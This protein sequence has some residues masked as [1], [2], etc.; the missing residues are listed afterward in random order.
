M[1]GIPLCVAVAM[2]GVGI[3]SA[4]VDHQ[5]DSIML[6]GNRVY[7]TDPG[8]NNIRHGKPS[9]VLKGE[10]LYEMKPGT[11][12]IRYDKQ[13]YTIDGHFS[14]TTEKCRWQCCNIFLF[15]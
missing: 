13:S 6:K 14:L 4:Q 11:T 15:I 8:T 5:E 3:A 7:Q 9:L 12:T 10:R 2:M 1:K